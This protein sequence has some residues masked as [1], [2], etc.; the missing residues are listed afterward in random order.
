MSGVPSDAP[1]SLH[2]AIHTL[3][4]MRRLRP[5]PVPE[6]ELRYLV[7]AATRAPSGENRQGWR[8]VVVTD[9]EQRRRLGEVYRGLGE[10]F[11]RDGALAGGRLDPETER[12]YR[13]AMV[14]VEQLGR[15]PALVVACAEG[16]PPAD[17]AGA[18]TWWGSIFPAVQNLLLAARARGL[19]ATLTTLH[20]AAED[21]VRA[22]L[23]IPPGVE[24]VALVPVGYPEGRFGPPRRRPAAEVTFWDRWGERR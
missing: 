2:E 11:I 21:E 4:A 3:R 18:A 7:E 10:R 14:L 9:P 17:P 16:P 13:H 23:A 24:A 6:A 15:A 12:V 1:L 5:D 8:F 19:G 20:R 22:I